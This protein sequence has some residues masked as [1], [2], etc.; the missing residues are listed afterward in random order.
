MSSKP[1]LVDFRVHSLSGLP[2]LDGTVELRMRNGDETLSCGTAYT[3]D[4]L[5]FLGA[6]TR[7]ALDEA[8]QD[9]TLE[10]RGAETGA[11]TNGAAAL[12]VGPAP[13]FACE[14]LLQ[15]PPACCPQVLHAYN[16]SWVLIPPKPK[17]VSTQQVHLDCMA[18]VEQGD[19]WRDVD[20]TLEWLP[21]HRSEVVQKVGVLPR[22]VWRLAEACSCRPCVLHTLPCPP[23]QPPEAHRCSCAC[24]LARRCCF[25]SRKLHE[26]FTNRGA[27]CLQPLL[28]TAFLTAHRKWWRLWS[29]WTSSKTQ[30]PAGRPAVQG[31]RSRRRRRRWS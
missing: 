29:G 18:A 2:T 7:F 5:V 11:Q 23:C 3:F 19:V 9:V 30:M 27:K 20:L 16:R 1:F 22:C 13:L 26:A 6:W 10:V 8:S 4:G 21:T 15:R 12:L 28:C 14:S 17:V 24:C 25:C 31:G